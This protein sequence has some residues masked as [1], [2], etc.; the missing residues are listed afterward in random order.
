LIRELRRVVGLNECQRPECLKRALSVPPKE[1][2]CSEAWQGLAARASRRD[3]R[4]A[5]ETF[6]IIHFPA[7]A[8]VGT[9]GVSAQV[10]DGRLSQRGKHHE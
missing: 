7:R 6:S 9:V 8:R 10:Q 2:L 5:I 3:S 4:K 1:T